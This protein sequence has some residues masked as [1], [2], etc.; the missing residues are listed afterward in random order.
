MLSRFPLFSGVSVFPSVVISYWVVPLVSSESGSTATLT[1]GRGKRRLIRSV[2]RA[3]RRYG[4]SS[5]LQP[6]SAHTRRPG[7]FESD[8]RLTNGTFIWQRSQIAMATDVS[9][10]VSRNMG[11]VTSYRQRCWVPSRW[12]TCRAL[13]ARPRTGT[14][15]PASQGIQYDQRRPAATLATSDETA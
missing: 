12:E 9:P 11:T 3:G 5:S 10:L 8:T 14:S 7:K 13:L 1:S 4:S 6:R 2:L 15:R